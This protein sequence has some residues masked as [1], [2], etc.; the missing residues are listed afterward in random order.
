MVFLY[1]RLFR[2]RVQDH[3]MIPRFIRKA[4]YKLKQNFNPAIKVK[5]EPERPHMNT[6]FPG[7]KLKS[8]TNDLELVSQDYLN[9][10]TFVNY[11]TSFGNYLIDC[12]QNT[13]L[14]FYTNIG[15]LPLGFN[16]PK[17]VEEIKKDDFSLA[18]INKLDTNNY[19]TEEF[20]N[21]FSKTVDKIKPKQLD[22]L[23]LTCGCGSSANELAIKVSMLRRGVNN[24]EE[25][26]RNADLSQLGSKWSILSFNHGF[27]GR[28][29]GAL[30]ATRS[31]AIQKIAQ[32]AFNW[33]M[34][35]FPELRYPLKENE[36][37]NLQEENRCLEETEKIL[38]NN[39]N[40]SAMI[41][42]PV[43]AE[44]GDFWGSKI[45]FRKLR[46]LA[47]AHNVDFIVDEVQ[48]GMATGRFWAHESWE[49][50]T[51]P[52][53][54]TF[55]KKFQVSGLFLREE[56]I[57]KNLNSDFCG[58]TC[59]DIFRFNTLSKILDV[60]ETEKLF[61]QSIAVANNFK[62]NF[63]EL[64]ENDKKLQN[65]FK[66]LRGQGSYLAF[67]LKDTTERNRFVNFSRNLGVF[68]SGCGDHSIR[69]RPTLTIKDHHY[70]FLLNVIREYP[71]AKI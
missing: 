68:V 10:Q 9:V 25:N 46:A 60:V 65:T 67:D 61:D 3:E 22:K 63:N 12:D 47:K 52:D 19:Y 21:R 8:L 37:A 57:P 43:Q 51:P 38:K 31:K 66:N 58:D 35:P 70:Q 62:K 29:G 69:L 36:A 4:L 56:I 44:G 34:A 54:V 28:I 24:N 40:V 27:H 49:L 1:H 18:F 16:H 48:T 41:V 2:P 59:F 55:S 30:T 23:L 26:I 17:L 6:H 32:P 5:R 7:P 53:M 71:E 33:P 50:E 64:V 42:E 15:S 11:D 14:D 13:Y 39:K 45:Y 20:Y